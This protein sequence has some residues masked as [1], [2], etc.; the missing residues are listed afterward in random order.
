MDTTRPSLLVRV[1]RDQEEAWREFDAIYRPMLDRFA[2]ARG[3]GQEDAED[4]T[5]YCMEAIYRHIKSFE[6]DPSKGRFKGWLRTLVNNRVRNLYRRR[7]ETIAKTQDFK[8][9]QNSE[10]S[11]DEVFDAIWMEEH[12]KQ[13]I[14][15]VRLEVEATTF[16]TF[17]RHVLDECSVAQVCEELGVTPNQVYKAKW[18]LTQ[19]LNDKM[20]ELVGESE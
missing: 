17:K 10:K 7:R 16:E 5:Q 11:P 12:L 9:Q 2:R 1:G 19:K 20:K 4:V 8:Q 14:R 15:M 6:Y 3:L 18:R 13:C